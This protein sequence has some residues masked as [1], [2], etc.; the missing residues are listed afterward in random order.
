MPLLTLQNRHAA[1]NC[2]S[3]KCRRCDE[4]GHRAA[5]CTNLYNFPERKDLSPIDPGEAW[6]IVVVAATATE[7]NTQLLRQVH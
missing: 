2:P 6:K 3:A 1:A 7:L 5:E 4:T